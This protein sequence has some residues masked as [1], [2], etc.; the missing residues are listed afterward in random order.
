MNIGICAFSFSGAIREAGLDPDPYDAY[1]LVQLAAENGLAGIELAG[2]SLPGRSQ[3][4]LSRFRAR[5]E[6]LGL[7]VTVSGGRVQADELRDVIPLAKA[8][9]A[10]TVR[11]VLSGILEGDRSKPPG[12]EWEPYVDGLI[13]EL[14]QVKGLAEDEGVAVAL[15]NHQDATSDD[16]LRVCLEVGSPMVGVNLD[17]GNAL[18]VAE[19][20]LS[21]AQ[22]VAPHLKNVHLKDYWIYLTESGYRLVRCPIGD[23]AVPFRDL[24][25]LFEEEA[26]EATLNIEI[27]ATSARH[28]RLLE[29]SFWAYYPPRA[30]HDVLGALRIAHTCARPLDE[31]WRTPHERGE[32]AAVRAEYELAQ[33][34]R[35]VENLR[36]ILAMSTRIR[37]PAWNR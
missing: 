13:E 12:P 34:R 37:C 15:E 4:E 28:I 29:D 35:S 27:G 2:T 11:T 36:R 1:G 25:A 3:P 7:N 5:L 23:G 20:P 19:E 18:A 16:L 21:F 6:E 8:V 26:P 17:A 24:F 32:S 14:R 10:K 31:D 30:L 9:G 22:K 33:F